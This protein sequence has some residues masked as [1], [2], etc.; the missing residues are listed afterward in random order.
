MDV[1]VVLRHFLFCLQRMMWMCVDHY[2]SFALLIA[3]F[4][5]FAYSFLLFCLGVE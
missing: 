5:L 1:Q 2:T 3:D 4:C